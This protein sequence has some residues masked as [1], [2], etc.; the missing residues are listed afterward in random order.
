MGIFRRW[1]MGQPSGF[2]TLVNRGQKGSGRLERKALS[3]QLRARALSAFRK[4][5]RRRP[6]K[7]S[8]S[9]T[10]RRWTR[11]QNRMGTKQD[12]TGSQSK[13]KRKAYVPPL[14]KQLSVDEAMGFLAAH[15]SREDQEA[16]DMLEILNQKTGQ[17]RK[18]LRIS[19]RLESE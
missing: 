9:G 19:L 14:V 8:E 2:Q 11:E 10:L 4:K 15:A 3:H 13:N 6:K 16:A 12:R 17:T 5:V 7:G 1:R 18:A